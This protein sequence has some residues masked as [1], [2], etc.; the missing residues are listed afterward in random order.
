MLYFRLNSRSAS[1]AARLL[2]AVGLAISLAACVAP[3]PIKDQAP[4]VSYP[5]TKKVAVVVIDSR[6][7]LTV[8]KKPPTFIGHAH[9]LF[10]IPTDMQ[11]YPWVALKEEKNFTLAQELEQRIVDALQADGATI[12]PVDRAAHAD[13]ASVKRVALGLDADRVLL[14]S[15]DK[16][17]I[18][19]NLSWVGS[20]ELDWGYTVAISDKTGAVIA[21]FADS[22][23]DVVEEKG[24]DSPR[25]MITEAFRARLEK[26][27]E[28]SEVRAALW[29]SPEQSSLQTMTRAK[30]Q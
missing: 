4:K 11:I 8:D 12:V 7:D 14:I 30:S 13:A 1:A 15:I 16:W 6:T 3:I 20:F 28:R 18:D 21:T 26:L 25:N 22:G 27:M 2:L 10:G 29:N 17:W 19:I 5:V 23:K 24:S 9:A